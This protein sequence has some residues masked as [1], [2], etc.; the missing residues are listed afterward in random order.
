MRDDNYSEEGPHKEVP[1]NTQS[2]ADTPS[3]AKNPV[4]VALVARSI[5]TA[6]AALNTD[7]LVQDQDPLKLTLDFLMQLRAGGPWQLSAADPEADPRHPKRGDIVTATITTIDGARTFLRTHNGH[8]NLYYAVN[9]VRHCKNKKAAKTD[10]AEIKFVPGDLDPQD[11]ETAEAAKARYQAALQSF[12]PKPMF[13]VDSGNG[14]QILWRLAE[15][16]LLP[17]EVAWTKDAKGRDKAILTPETQAIVDNVEARSKVAMEYLGAKAG[18]QNIDRILRLP[19]TVNLPNAVKLKKGRKPCQSSLLAYDPSAICQLQDFDVLLEQQDEPKPKQEPP[20]KQEGPSVDSTKGTLDEAALPSKLKD[21]IYSNV[22]DGDRSDQFFHAVKWLKQLGWNETDITA[23][24]VKY[25]A[26]IA[27]KYIDRLDQEVK[28]AYDKPDHYPPPKAAPPLPRL[29]LTLDQWRERDLPKPDFLMGEILHTTNRS[30]M[31]AKTGLGKTNLGLA[32]GMR[33]SSG[34]GFLHWQAGRSCKVLYIDG[35]MSRRLLK[36]RLMLEEARFELE[37]GRRP[38]GFYALSR[39]DLP[40][41]QPLNAPEGQA[42]INRII[43]EIGG[44]NFLIL[45]NIQALIF[46]SMIDEEPWAQTLPWVKA[47]TRSCIGQLWLHH[48]GHDE[49]HS[50]GTKTREWQLD[51]VIHLTEVKHPATDISFE[52]KFDKARERSPQNRDDYQTINIRLVNDEWLCDVAQTGK[53]GKV[54]P[55]CKKFLDAL[56]NVAAGAFTLRS[57]RLHGLHAVHSDDWKAECELLGLLDP[58]EKP[59]SSRALF[60]KHR[61]EL[62]AADMIACQGD[63]SWLR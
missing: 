51:N 30:L 13:V 38:T 34:I 55:L 42:L 25:P 29:F 50:Y 23:L 54:S 20:P 2:S 52:L 47:L 41:M 11:D 45:D 35:E 14:I 12:T 49:S 43:T 6:K 31:S 21:L 61:R 39:E 4:V 62:V 60:S 32:V 26:G 59:D 8:M 24:L 36:Q 22:K 27:E 17:D 16:I 1:N 53:K 18:T 19:W 15:P 33:M 10:V 48:T 58:K 28:R 57:K 7:A 3:E 56:V 40:D 5:A 46:G 37:A 44:C 63:Y 9:P